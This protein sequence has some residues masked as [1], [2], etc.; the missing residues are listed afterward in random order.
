MSVAQDKATEG[1]G[2]EVSTEHLFVGL[3]DSNGDVAKLLPKQQPL[4]RALVDAALQVQL[5]PTCAK[6]L[7]RRAINLKGAS[8]RTA[9]AR[10][11]GTAARG[12][13]RADSAERASSPDAGTPGPDLSGTGS[14]FR[15]L[16]RAGTG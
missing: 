13:L 16:P 2:D 7:A 3:I 14:T 4:P 12:P 5:A 11:R 6:Q 9:G 1:R 8:A 10:T 15:G